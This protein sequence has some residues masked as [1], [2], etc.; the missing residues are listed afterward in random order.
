MKITSRSEQA[1]AYFKEGYNCSQ[2][3]FLAFHDLYDMEFDTAL[4]I[5]SSFGAGMGR[6]REVCGAVTG[7]FMT[8]GL[9]YGSEDPKNHVL[10]TEHYKR[11]QFL[12]KKFEDENKSIICRD[13]LGLKPGKDNPTPDVRT[14]EYYKKR[15]CV[16]LVGMATDI[17]ENYMA[18]V[19]PSSLIMTKEKPILDAI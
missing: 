16:E 13:L 9:V 5:S 1:M 11:I 4:K 7:M 6:L 10:K 14:A 18:A 3:V 17:L 12:A 2:S 19:Q 8:A 15:P